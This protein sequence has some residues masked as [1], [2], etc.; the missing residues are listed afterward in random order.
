MWQHEISKSGKATQQP[1]PQKVGR[2]PPRLRPTAPMTHHH[3]HH[4]KI[5]QQFSRGRHH[6]D[7]HSQKHEVTVISESLE[8]L[9]CCNWAR[10]GYGRLTKWSVSWRHFRSR[11]IPETV[12][13]VWTSD[14]RVDSTP[15]ADERRRSIGLKTRQNTTRSQWPV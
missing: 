10:S 1:I 11:R 12:I 5:S 3:H 9:D 13:C 2:R 6:A 14:R 7:S 4:D 8:T 15:E